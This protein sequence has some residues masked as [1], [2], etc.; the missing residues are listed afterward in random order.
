MF[1]KIKK[2]E[3]FRI[4]GMLPKILLQI[5]SLYMLSL[6]ILQYLYKKSNYIAECW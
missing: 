6:F 2:E 4:F 5:N 1:I 3:D